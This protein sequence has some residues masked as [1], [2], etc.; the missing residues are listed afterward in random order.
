[1][2]FENFTKTGLKFVEKLNNNEIKIDTCPNK[3]VK[4]SLDVVENQLSK[5]RKNFQKN[6]NFFSL[7]K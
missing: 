1:M 3:G 2:T 5:A 6:K 7:I 4:F